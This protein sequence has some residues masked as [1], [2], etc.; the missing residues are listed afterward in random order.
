MDQTKTLSTKFRYRQNF[1]NSGE[2][3]PKIW[4]PAIW[5]QMFSVASRYPR[6]RPTPQHR[7]ET[8]AFYSNLKTAL[9]C[10]ECQKSYCLFFS[11]IPIEDYLSSRRLLIEWVYLIKS[12]VNQKLIWQET[13]NQAKYTQECLKASPDRLD[14]CVE[15]GKRR[16]IFRTTPSPPL[17]NI[18]LRYL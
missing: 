18:L 3:D 17:S 4:G 2:S 16:Q 15:Y 11:Q 1:V 14:Y 8:R 12:K 7:Y 13:N 5:R 10:S 9:P 6:E